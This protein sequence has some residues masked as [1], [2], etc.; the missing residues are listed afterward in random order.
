LPGLP[1]T[2]WFRPGLRLQGVRSEEDRPFAQLLPVKRDVW[3]PRK[4]VGDLPAPVRVELPVPR[5][6]GAGELPAIA[7][8]PDQV[9]FELL[10]ICLDQLRGFGPGIRC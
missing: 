7:P 6:V 10:P 3:L 8:S 5:G 4:R 2:L 9:V 1:T